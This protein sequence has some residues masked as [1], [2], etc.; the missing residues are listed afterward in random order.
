MMKK[1]IILLVMCICV[2]GTLGACKIKSD[3]KMS[4][5]EI[6]NLKSEYEKYLNET[7]PDETFT[8]DLWQE[9]GET[10][11]PAGLPDYEGYLMRQVITDSK[12]NRFKISTSNPGVYSD[13]YQK[14]LDGMVHYNEKGSPDVCRRR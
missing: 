11:G 13:D 1:R 6:N 9:Y 8:I 7:Y 12:G 5:K 2:L 10:T 14:V 3:K 4:D